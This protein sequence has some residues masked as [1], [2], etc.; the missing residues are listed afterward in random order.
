MGP[1]KKQKA[2]KNLFVVQ[3]FVAGVCV[4]SVSTDSVCVY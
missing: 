1:R 3:P 4:T 2:E